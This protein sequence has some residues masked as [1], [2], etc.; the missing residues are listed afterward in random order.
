MFNYETEYIIRKVQN[1]VLGERE[2]ITLRSILSAPIHSA[3]KVYFRA[4]V[5]DKHGSPKRFHKEQNTNIDKLKSEIDLLLPSNYSF[6]RDTCLTLLTDAVHFQ[7]NYLCRP[8]WTMKEF[9]FHNSS[10]LTIPELKQGFIYFSAYDYYPKI[11]FPYL[12]KKKITH[13]ESTSFDELI[14]KIDRLAL[15]DAT[16]DD[17]AKLLQPLS[18]FIRYGR[19]TNDGSIP[20]HALSLFFDDK[21][22]N[23]I[24]TH[25]ESTLKQKQ[26]EQITIDELREYLASMPDNI[27]VKPEEAAAQTKAAG[28]NIDDKPDPPPVIE[29]PYEE[30]PEPAE[31]T[32]DISD[33]AELEP[34]EDFEKT[35]GGD[36]QNDQPEAEK[37]SEPA[38]KSIEDITELKPQKTASSMPP[39]E[40]LIED[41]ERKR[42]IRRLF[43]ND[44]AYFEVVVQTLNKI[45]SWKEASLYIDEIFLVNG[46]DPYSTDAV[47][48]TDKVYTRFN[49]KSV[50]NK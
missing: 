41:D 11:L 49:Q 26:I 38:E 23:Y 32:T 13:I 50:Y 21:Q 29:E 20:E 44:A 43:N 37:E 7:F 36:D 39:L 10:T 48:F 35:L 4:S 18:D 34:K 16:A 1:K 24:K 28:E 31:T 27:D 3:I 17:F 12:R 19:E 30:E 14:L 47:N 25:L 6:D 33:R 45:L 15:G 2:S 9:F 22:F 42:F 46:V 40:L 8:R 5:A